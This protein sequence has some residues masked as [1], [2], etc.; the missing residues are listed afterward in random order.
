M[1]N[2]ERP[3]SAPARAPKPDASWLITKFLGPS[4]KENGPFGLLGLHPSDVVEDDVL[5]GLRARLQQAA[6]HAEGATPE[7]DEVRLALHAAAAQ[8]LDAT[9]RRAMIQRWSTAPSG[10]PAE[11]AREPRGDPALSAGRGRS[12]VPAVAS[13]GPSESDQR[14]QSDQRPGSGAPHRLAPADRDLLLIQHEAVLAIAACG[15]WN[16]QARAHLQMFAHA[17]AIPAQALIAAISRLDRPHAASDAVARLGASADAR[18]FAGRGAPTEPVV[19]RSNRIGSDSESGPGMPPVLLWAVGIAAGL[20]VLILA[21]VSV[22]VAGSKRG[23]SP[24]AGAQS[25]PSPSAPPARDTSTQAFPWRPETSKPTPSISAPATTD[26][27]RWLQELTGSLDASSQGS[28]QFGRFIKALGEGATRWPDLSA[29]D[30]TVAQRCIVDALYVADTHDRAVTI[31]QAIAPAT[32]QA[33][34]MVRT[35]PEMLRAVWSAGVLNRISRERDLPAAVLDVVERALTDRL[36]RERPTGE[37]AFEAGALAALHLGAEAAARGG[38]GQLWDGWIRGAGAIAVLQPARRTDLL[39]DG[40]AHACAGAGATEDTGGP[41]SGAWQSNARAVG[42][43]VPM[44][45]WHREQGAQRWLLAQFDAFDTPPRALVAIAREMATRSTVPGVD[46]TMVLPEP[47]TE[48]DRR[49]LRDRYARLFG[50]DTEEARDAVDER[51]AGAIAAVE[52]RTPGTMME[53]LEVALAW[54][55][56]S[57]AAWLHWRGVPARAIEALTALESA[58]TTSTSAPSRH[59]DALK[60]DDPPE[61]ARSYIA[62]GSDIPRRTALLASFPSGDPLAAD[63]EIV[64]AEALRGSPAQVREAARDIVSRHARSPTMVNAMLE[65]IPTA[66][67]TLS[68]AEVATSLTDLERVPMDVPDWRAVVRRALVE[69]MLTLLAGRGELAAIDELALLLAKSHEVRSVS[70]GPAAPSEGRAAPDLLASLAQERASWRAASEDLVRPRS[71]PDSLAA[72][73]A[74]L[75][76]RLRIAEGSIQRAVA[77]ECAIVRYMAIVVACERP[78]RMDQVLATIAEVSVS[79]ARARDVLEQFCACE[80]ACA[81]LWA[82][83]LGAETP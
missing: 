79:V 77:E 14:P 70:P 25:A 56:L 73:D 29:P 41:A 62:A 69:R 58:G 75:S 54:S 8:L 1:T 4:A 42:I 40:L 67:R 43:L 37:P 74:D 72:I 66:P 81:R 34:G 44:I 59:G 33:P 68:T 6:S 20:V 82:L 38:A 3:G 32:D 18:T 52:S 16:E 50:M 26:S 51:W 31:L 64:L 78:D 49:L 24:V 15:G 36:G 46:A 61:W 11:L 55:R 53:S 57:E 9:T 12:P 17:R 63:A 80:R 23:P 76:A 5:S 83:R 47:F 21:T 10:A 45:A 2:P 35:S 65:A 60:R 30:L 27:Q 13:P 7:A 22:L 19:T 39:L 71:Y 28:D 48:A